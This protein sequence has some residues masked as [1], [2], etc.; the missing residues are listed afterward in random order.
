MKLDANIEDK[1]N[2]CT[3]GSGDITDFNVKECRCNIQD[4][5]LCIFPFYWNG[6]LIDK[7]A[8]LEQEEFLYPVFRCPI[9]NVTRKI[10]GINSFV[11][12]DFLKQVECLLKVV[13]CQ[14]VTST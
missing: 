14:V 1:N 5:N 12:S 7:C 11:F 9:R 3:Q 13:L 8:F 6:K 10:E 4:E 2:E